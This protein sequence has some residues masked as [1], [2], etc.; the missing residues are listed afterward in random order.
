LSDEQRRE[1]VA[2][3]ADLL[4][5]AEAKRRGVGS[6][7]FTGSASEVA[8]GSVISLPQKRAKGA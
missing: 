5:A 8:I 6:G 2:L 7:G 1:A 4:L 3:L